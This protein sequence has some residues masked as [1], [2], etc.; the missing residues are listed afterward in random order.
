MTRFAHLAERVKSRLGGSSEPWDTSA[1]VK[2]KGIFFFGQTG[3]KSA[4]NVSIHHTKVPREYTELIR[5]PG[6]DMGC[7]KKWS[8]TLV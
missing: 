3:S 4:Q 5:G 2:I 8:V 1:V 6:E 7:V